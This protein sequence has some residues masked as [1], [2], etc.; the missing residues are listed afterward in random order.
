MCKN[1]ATVQ[2]QVLWYT[3][4]YKVVLSQTNELLPSKPNML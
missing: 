1:D 3:P 2:I 4:I